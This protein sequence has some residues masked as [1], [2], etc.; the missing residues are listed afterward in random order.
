[1]YKIWTSCDQTCGEEDCLQ[2]LCMCM[3]VP[4]CV[5]VCVVGMH[6]CVK[7]LKEELKIVIS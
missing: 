1:M 4:V 5:Y 6:V 7:V 2:I 3:C